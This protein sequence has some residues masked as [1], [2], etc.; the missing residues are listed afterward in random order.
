V[1]VV[2]CNGG[3]FGEGA[4]AVVSERLSG[5]ETNVVRGDDVETGRLRGSWETGQ[6]QGGRI[7]CG[8]SEKGLNG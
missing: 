8:A 5:Y 2:K 3:E 1:V 6:V 4:G 7:A